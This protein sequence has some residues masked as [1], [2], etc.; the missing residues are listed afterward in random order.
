MISEKG[1]IG[2]KYR[3]V[4]DESDSESEDLEERLYQVIDK[5]SLIKGCIKSE[6]RVEV[7]LWLN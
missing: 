2:K 6:D 7:E 3:N 5:D 4:K 1:N